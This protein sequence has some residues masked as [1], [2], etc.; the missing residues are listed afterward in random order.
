MDF[1]RFFGWIYTV[2]G[3]K[4]EVRLGIYGEVNA[5]KTTLANRI[6]VDWTGT[7]VGKVSRIPHETRFVQK[8]EK[9]EIKL[10]SKK[11]SINLL[12][13]P[14]LATKVNYKTFLKYGISKKAAK[15]RAKEAT[16]G[17][18]EAIK[19]LDNVDTVLAVMDATRDP[20]TQVNI[21]LLGNL[22]AKKIPVIIVANKVDLKNQTPMQSEKPFRNIH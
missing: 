3:V 10:N 9:V 14:G 16:D 7:P 17:I 1:G 21:T 2:F 19:W 22:E 4:R 12:D 18:I 6:S 8:K 20:M 11:L 15:R 13:M 5:G